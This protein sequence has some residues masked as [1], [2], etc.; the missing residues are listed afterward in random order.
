MARKNIV[1]TQDFLGKIEDVSFDQALKDRYLAY[2]LATITSRSLPAVR[3]GLKPVQRRILYAMFEGGNVVGKPFRKSADALGNVMRKYHPHGDGPIYEALVRMAQDFSCRYPLIEGQGNF[4]SID[5]DG[6]AAF[7]YTEARLSAYGEALLNGIR[8]NAVDFCPTAT[9]NGEEPV[10]LPG[11]LPNLLCNGSAGVAVGMA[12]NIPPHNLKDVIDTCL[13]LLEKPDTTIAQLMKKLKGPDFPTGGV[14]IDT[15]AQLEK[16]YAAGRGSLKNRA[17]WVKETL[18]GGGYEIIVTEI[19]YQVQKSRLISRIADL[20]EEKKL[21]LLSDIRDESEEH[22]RLVLVPRSRTVPPEHLMASLFPKTELEVSFGVNL[23][24]LLPNG[25]PQVLSLGQMI[26]HFLDHRRDVLIRRSTYCRDKIESRLHLLDGLLMIFNH[27]DEIIRIIRE[28]EEPKPE[29]MKAFPL[30]DL[31]AEAIL[32]TKWRALRKLEEMVLRDEQAA[33]LLERGTLN[34]VIADPRVQSEIMA[35]N[36]KEMRQKFGDARRTLLEP[37]DAISLEPEDFH[38]VREPVTV[39]INNKAWVKT[40]KGHDG[41]KQDVD[42]EWQWVLKAWTGQ[43]LHMMEPGGYV[44][45]VPIDQLPGGRT[46]GEPLGLILKA[47][48]EILPLHAW[49][50]EPMKSTPAVTVAAED[51]DEMPDD[52][53]ADE[54]TDGPINAPVDGEDIWFVATKQGR[55]FRIT[56]SNLITQ[57][58]S[59]RKVVNLAEGD[60]VILFQKVSGTH[61]ACVGENRKLLIFAIDEVPLVNRGRG[62]I[63]QRFRD[64]GLSDV[65]IFSMKEGKLWRGQSIVLDE[66]DLGPWIMH[67]AGQGRFA[68]PGFPRSNKFN[69]TVKGT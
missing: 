38:Q 59:G 12:T 37:T 67:R 21:P 13:L 57:T 46:Q 41:D 8:E 22:I 10:V 5:G 20:L 16:I 60:H 19:P 68:P 35:K 4:G 50:P 26:Q 17:T 64:G 66:K 56:A 15:P 34:D 18:K 69:A 43:R 25:V 62:V 11:D 61:V 48:R 47:G 9:S 53:L 31:Q 58:K 6:P 54:D 40:V 65:K 30:S 33:L 27:L 63:L 42:S 32:N 28:S 29:L 45:S 55:G 2:A 44:F 3:D 51:D 36:L 39:L 49:I 52:G 1:D 23:N 24:M 14:V 7:R